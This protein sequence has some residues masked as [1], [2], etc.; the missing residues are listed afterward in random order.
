[1]LNT[2]QKRADLTPYVPR[3]LTDWY[4]S[5]SGTAVHSLTRHQGTI[6]FIDLSGFTALTREFGTAGFE[7]SEN[8]T[9]LINRYF[10]LA[11]TA[12][13][14]DDGDIL[15]FVGDA[16]WAYFPNSTDVQGLFRRISAGLQAMNSTLTIH[17]SA[18][19]GSFYLMSAGDAASR[20]EAE[21]TGELI[22]RVMKLADNASG[23]QLVVGDNLKQRPLLPATGPDFS[24]QVNEASVRLRSY[25]AP[26]I[27]ARFDSGELPRSFEYEHRDVAVLFTDFIASGDLDNVE[28]IENLRQH[29]SEVFRIVTCHGGNIARL[30]PTGSGHKLLVLFGAPVQHQDDSLHALQCA[31]DILAL[32]GKT[33]VSRVGLSSGPLFCGDVGVEWRREYTVMGEPVNL[34]ARLMSSAAVGHILLDSATRNRLPSQV[35]TTPR[36]VTIKGYSQPVSIFEFDGISDIRTERDQGVNLVGRQNELIELRTICETVDRGSGQFVVLTGPVGIGKS[37]VIAQLLD[38]RPENSHA[39]ECRPSLLYGPGW[40]ARTLLEKLLNRSHRDS[41]S[42]DDFIV[43]HVDSSWLPLLSPLLKIRIAENEWT[44]GLKP[45]L[46]Y[47]KSTDLFAGLMGQVCIKP[48]VVMIDDIDRADEYS[49]DLILGLAG[50]MRSIPIVLILS[51]R[52][53]PSLPETGAADRIHLLQ[54]D[55]PSEAAWWQFFGEQFHDGKL[56]RELFESLLARSGGNPLFIKQYIEQA[57]SRGTLVASTTSG[58]LELLPGY[59]VAE[60]PNSIREALLQR[61]DILPE[62][63]RQTLKCASVMPG[64]FTLDELDIVCEGADKKDLARQLGELTKSGILRRGDEENTYDFTHTSLREIIYSCLPVVQRVEFHGLIFMARRQ[65]PDATPAI[66]AHHAYQ[67]N[68]WADAFAFSLRA[69]RSA[70]TTFSLTEA[71]VY[72]NQCESSLSRTSIDNID[73][74]A[75]FDFYSSFMKYAEITGNIHA[76]YRSNRCWRR[77][78]RIL[79]DERQWFMAIAETSHLMWV[80]S[81]YRHCERFLCSSLAGASIGRFPEIHARMLSIRAEVHRRRGEFEQAI[82]LADQAVKLIYDRDDRILR[83]SVYNKLGLA[84]WGAG[85][86]VE[87]AGAYEQSLSLG[88]E[89]KSARAQATNNLA[90][91]RWEQGD[92]LNAEHLMTEALDIFKHIGDRR[93]ESYVAGNLASL[94]QIFGNYAKARELLVEADTVFI[95]AGDEHAHHYA[96]GNIADIDL[97]TGDLQAARQKYEKVAAFAATVDDKELA[98]ECEVRLGEHAFY[99]G[100]AE[101]AQQ[102]YRRAIVSAESIGSKEFLVRGSIG[103]ARLLVGNRNSIELSRVVERVR[104]IASETS[105]VLPLHEVNFLEGEKFR[106]DGDIAEAVDR[107]QQ[108]LE[109][110]RTQRLFELTLKCA[111]R[112]FELSSKSELRAK[113]LLAQLA[114]DYESDNGE[115]SW[116]RLIDSPY[117]TFFARTLLKTTSRQVLAES[118]QLWE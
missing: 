61:F 33:C 84:L 59:P 32:T 44:S 106:L 72:F 30:D 69:A 57:T 102:R 52:N 81:K 15:K 1:M 88:Q 40:V 100:Q 82:S 46:R 107:Y 103:L 98:A 5:A 115:G 62:T 78:A 75:L 79:T 49:R 50:V 85:M 105:A 38:Q 70:M 21:A 12:I 8:L 64:V 41:C 55:R 92:F 63:H 113:K 37:A 93:N 4:T 10:S 18:E 96:M 45:E 110:A 6:M 104:A 65:T 13:H 23:G 43:A 48:Q 109:Y 28:G 29:L 117:F 95:R 24:S 86:L 71:G 17:G 22:A 26:E 66:L 94:F 16:I 80:Q 99:S 114:S 111:V 51:A 87:A 31:R 67:A 47:T 74:A 3:L 112:L 76:A 20:T 27:L 73:H 14:S 91:I 97:I 39:I 60:V 116:G 118:L 89:G 36:L 58:K 54:L 2:V 19:Y 53:S 77:A 7:G 25:I 108:V 9:N 101:E 90:I 56:E 83:A 35:A 34:A 11:A 68:L 42:L